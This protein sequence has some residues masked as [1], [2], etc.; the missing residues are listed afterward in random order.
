MTLEYTILLKTGNRNN[1]MVLL[2]Q[3]IKQKYSVSIGGGLVIA[4]IKET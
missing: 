1:S 3:N 2:G 4:G